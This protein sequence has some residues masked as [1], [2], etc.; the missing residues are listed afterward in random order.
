MISMKAG[1]LL[2][3]AQFLEPG[4]QWVQ[5]MNSMNTSHV[6]PDEECFN[7]WQIFLKN[8]PFSCFV[9]LLCLVLS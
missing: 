7:D 8:L 9:I 1:A 3:N 5:L 2:Y 4:P 6:L